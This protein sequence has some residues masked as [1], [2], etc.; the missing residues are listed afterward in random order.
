MPSR[1]PVRI[2]TS[3]ADEDL[4]FR[5]MD[6]TEEVGRLFLYDLDLV[7][8]R[9][10]LALD[11]VLGHPACVEL[12]LPNGGVRYFHGYVTHFSLT[13]RRGGYAAYSMQL[14]PWLW[15]LTR[16]ADCRIFQ[17]KTAPE[18]LQEGFRQHG[19]SGCTDS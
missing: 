16:T 4:L 6:G 11:D 3:L 12:D 14:R 5:A 15:F 8:P 2:K 13:G 18:I 10:D 7:S 17:N 1:P 19:F 9:E